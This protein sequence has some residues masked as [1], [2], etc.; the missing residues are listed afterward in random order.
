[1]DPE[2]ATAGAFKTGEREACT[3]VV[4]CSGKPDL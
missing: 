4:D 3:V 1:M 2:T